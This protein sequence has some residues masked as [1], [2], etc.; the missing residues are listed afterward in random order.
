MTEGLIYA[1]IAAKVE[2]DGHTLDLIEDALLHVGKRLSREMLSRKRS[3]HHGDA[4]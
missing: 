1:H 3:D 2:D 4:V